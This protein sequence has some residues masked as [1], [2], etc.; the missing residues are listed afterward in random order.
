MVAITKSC[1]VVAFD[2]NYILLIFNCFYFEAAGQGLLTKRD[3]LGGKT[4]AK[5]A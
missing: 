4:D 2:L 3:S 5:I 1:F